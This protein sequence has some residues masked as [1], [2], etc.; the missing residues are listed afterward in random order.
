LCQTTA[1]TTQQQQQQKF[2][3]KLDTEKDLISTDTKWQTAYVQV[4][5]HWSVTAVGCADGK[6]DKRDGWEP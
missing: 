1:T 3:T 6:A 4:G 2:K 5:A